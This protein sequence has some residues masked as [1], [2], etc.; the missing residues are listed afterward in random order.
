M[1]WPIINTQGEYCMQ[2]KMDV[3]AGSGVAAVG[4]QSV[5]V[6]AAPQSIM[7]QVRQGCC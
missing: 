4:A 2:I 6:P 5:R 1:C 7:R 3:I